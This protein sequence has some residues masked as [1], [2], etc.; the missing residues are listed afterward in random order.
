MIAIRW[1]LLDMTD[2]HRYK[3]G[4]CK[5]MSTQREFVCY[6]DIKEIKSLIEDSHLEMRPS[7][8]TQHA[9]FSNVFVQGC[10]NCV[11]VW[12]LTPLWKC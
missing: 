10:I 6:H 2:G 3:C 1:L 9:D 12:P 8:I 4:C 7:C 11:F 5:A